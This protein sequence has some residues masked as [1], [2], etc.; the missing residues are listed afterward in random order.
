MTNITA[1]F[2]PSCDYRLQ[3]ADCREQSERASNAHHKEN[4]LKIAQQWQSLA[5]T[6]EKYHTQKTSS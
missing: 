5:E 6:A 3:A 2:R 1:Q 4:W